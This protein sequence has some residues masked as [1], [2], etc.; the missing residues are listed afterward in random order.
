MSPAQPGPAGLKREIGLFGTTAPGTG[1]I[2]GS[3]I[4]VVTGI[5]AGITGPAMISSVLIAGIIGGKKQVGLKGFTSHQVRCNS[6]VF[7][8]TERYSGVFSTRTEKGGFTGFF[9]IDQ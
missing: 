1:A 3:G 6:A 9:N 7:W 4:F 2:I 5:I 8:Q